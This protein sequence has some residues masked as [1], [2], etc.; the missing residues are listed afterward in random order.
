[1]NFLLQI[2]DLA[3][4]C[5]IVKY[6][7]DGTMYEVCTIGST[8]NIQESVDI[9]ISWSEENNM[10]INSEEMLICFCKDERHKESVPNLHVNGDIIERV[11]AS[12][13]LG[14]IVSDDLSWNAHVESIVTKAGK[15]LYEHKPCIL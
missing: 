4:P 1:M 7:D 15:R 6:V 10:C 11:S 2:N 9:A 5:P 8:S 12:K 3:T 13:V 14:V